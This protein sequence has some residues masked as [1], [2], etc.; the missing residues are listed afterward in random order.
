[1]DGLELDKVFGVLL[2]EGGLPALIVFLWYLSDR[3]AMASIDRLSA[4]LV[5]VALAR[6]R[7]RKDRDPGNGEEAVE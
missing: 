2:R 5:Q 4:A 7:P 6:S 3:R 1:M